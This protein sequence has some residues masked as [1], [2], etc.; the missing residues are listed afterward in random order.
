MGKKK[1]DRTGEI[2]FNKLG[3]KMEIIGYRNFHDMDVYFPEYNW[4]F[5]NCD[6]GN[7]KRGNVKCPYELS[8]FGVGYIGEGKYPIRENGKPT[9]CYKTWSHMLERCY[10][11]KYQIKNPTYINCVVCEEWHNFQNFAEWFYKNYYEINNDVMYLD[12]DILTKHNKIYSPQTCVFV[13]NRINTLFCN[14]K[15]DR[16]EYPIGVH[17][18]TNNINKFSSNC[19]DKN[20]NKVFLGSYKTPEEAFQVYKEFKEKVIKE[21]A[22]EYKPYIPDILYQAM[23]RYE[24]EITD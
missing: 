2:R 5:K 7:F 21:V 1:I 14:R 24:V 23:Y 11:E 22:E 9:K 12:K 13:N 10:N 3:S 17:L 20:N 18:N 8:V 15:R 19:S 16:G 4:I 6:F